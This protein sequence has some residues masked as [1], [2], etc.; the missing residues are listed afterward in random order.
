MFAIIVGAMT[1][2]IAHEFVRVFLPEFR[3]QMID[4]SQQ[5]QSP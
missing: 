1:F 5:L 3:N 2:V 4:L